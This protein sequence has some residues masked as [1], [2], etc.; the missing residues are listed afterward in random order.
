[1]GG[2]TRVARK[3]KFHS[4][5]SAAIHKSFARTTADF[6]HRYLRKTEQTMA[7]A[8]VPERP[9]KLDLES[10]YFWQALGSLRHKSLTIICD[11]SPKAKLEDSCRQME[12]HFRSSPLSVL[13]ILPKFN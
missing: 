4:I 3:L 1:M 9:N 7:E 10:L 5:S 2:L 8:T 13:N 12:H 6:I 11:A